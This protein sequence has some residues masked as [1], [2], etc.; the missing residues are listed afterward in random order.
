VKLL[1]LLSACTNPISSKK[2][3]EDH[4]IIVMDNCEYIMYSYESGCAGY[5]F[6]AHRGQCK[7]C[8]ERRSDEKSK[9]RIN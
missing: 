4:N 6:M 8:K 5:G 7:Y 2:I 1:I 3:G 9:I